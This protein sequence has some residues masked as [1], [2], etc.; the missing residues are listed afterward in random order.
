LDVFLY[1][2]LKQQTPSEA[3]EIHTTL[4]M[5]FIKEESE[6]IMRVIIKEESEDFN[7]V[8]VKEE[9]TEEHTGWFHSQI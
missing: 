6:D 1:S 7:I 9:D 4:K 5:A 2:P 8:I 3:T